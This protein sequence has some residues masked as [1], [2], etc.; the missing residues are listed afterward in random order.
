[1][2]TKVRGR[3]TG[4][5][6]T[7]EIAERPEDSRVEVEVQTGTIQTNQ[8]QRD[9]HLRSGDFLEIEKYPKLT[10]KSKEL[11]FTGGPTLQI[12]GDLT[13]KDITREVTL[14]AEFLGWGPSPTG[15]NVLSFSARTTI[16]REDWDMTWNMVVETGGFLVSRKVDLEIDV[17]AI[18]Q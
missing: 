11:R 6:G 17:E 3:F 16:D 5:H 8:E 12:V 14:E 4:F 10:F 15:G 2:F 9:T 1:M 13:I 18:Q 7:I